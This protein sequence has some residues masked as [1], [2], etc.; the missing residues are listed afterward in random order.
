MDAANFLNPLIAALSGLAGVGIGG[1]L[2][3]HWSASRDLANERRKLRISY[4]LEAYRR[5]EASA[6]RPV[7]TDE[8]KAAFESAVADIQLLGTKDQIEA[9]VKFLRKHTQRSGAIIDSVLEIL[10]ADLRQE[11]GLHG[12]TPHVVVFRFIDD[13]R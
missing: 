10:R 9:T 11:M 2:S 3:H 6:N 1:W 4:L 5:L 8:Q 7:G 12:N 13:D